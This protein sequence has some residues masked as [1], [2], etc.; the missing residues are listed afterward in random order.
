MVTTAFANNVTLVVAGV[1][2]L[3]PTVQAVRLNTSQIQI[4]IHSVLRAMLHA[5]DAG[6]RQQTVWHVLP[7][8]MLLVLATPVSM[9]D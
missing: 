6:I 1:K 8:T 7:V 4:T 3:P 2:E 9:T 5:T